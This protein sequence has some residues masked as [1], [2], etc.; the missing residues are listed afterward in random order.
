M[1]RRNP[2]PTWDEAENIW[3]RL[4]GDLGKNVKEEY[5]RLALLYH[6]D[7]AGPESTA[8]F[9]DL[10]AAYEVLSGEVRPGSRR[11]QAPPPPRPLN[12]TDQALRKW[13]LFRQRNVGVDYKALVAADAVVSAMLVTAGGAR[14]FVESISLTG[15]GARS[16][17]GGYGLRMENPP[18]PG[19]G[20]LHLVFLDAVVKRAIRG[21]PAETFSNV[22]ISIVDDSILIIPKVEQRYEPNVPKGHPSTRTSAPRR[23]HRVVEIADAWL[24]SNGRDPVANIAEW[25]THEE[26]SA[27][28]G[29]AARARLVP[30][31]WLDLLDKQGWSSTLMSLAEDLK[32]GGYRLRL[33]SSCVL[34]FAMLGPR[35]GSRRR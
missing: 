26:Y 24:G 17:R 16:P 20:D 2:P 29:S 25:Q 35:R 27:T 15:Y 6:P 30:G 11:Y 7:I 28:P 12:W 23:F 32:A 33:K 34:E 13:S 21:S 14:V 1:A 22:S 5:R 3:L 31:S 4:G 18:R 10:Q 19:W 8:T 9:Q